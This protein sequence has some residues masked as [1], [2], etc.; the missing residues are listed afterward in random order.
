[1]S[2]FSRLCITAASPGGPPAAVDEWGNRGRAGLL[3]SASPPSRS[4]GSSLL[5]SPLPPGTLWSKSTGS[6]S[7]RKIMTSTEGA[8]LELRLPSS[9]CPRTN[10]AD[11]CATIL[12]ISSDQ[13]VLFDSLSAGLCAVSG[14]KPSLGSLHLGQRLSLTLRMRASQVLQTECPQGKTYLSD[15]VLLLP[16]S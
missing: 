6:A 3:L 16:N 15:S 5:S 14:V 11:A 4:S 8:P 12:N 9:E 1:M 7:E 10:A 13:T 2:G